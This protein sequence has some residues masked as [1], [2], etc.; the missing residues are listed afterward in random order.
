MRRS[1]SFLSLP[2]TRLGGVAL[3]GLCGFLFGCVP[4]VYL[5][6]DTG[7]RLVIDRGVDVT[8]KES[9]AQQRGP[10]T[11]AEINQALTKDL[12]RIAIPADV[13]QAALLVPPASF[14]EAFRNLAWKCTLAERQRRQSSDVQYLTFIGLLGAG[15]VSSTAAATLG[16]LSEIPADGTAKT[17]LKASGI[18]MGGLA[19][20]FNSLMAAT[21]IRKSASA[22]R[23]KYG[24]AQLAL[25][26]AQA[27]WPLIE[28][29]C[30]DKVTAQIKDDAT[31][32]AADKSTAASA[33][34][35]EQR[36]LLGQCVADRKRKILLR[37]ST[38]CLTE[39][40]VMGGE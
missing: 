20:I 25:G 21:A 28:D 2:G 5:P 24:E 8:P 26:D 10:V 29:S 30:H 1:R 18:V 23:A 11:A 14:E 7:K 3:G 6:P 9:G 13:T 19:V 16:G 34:E 27:E 35:A 36:R 39:P 15:L 31:S 17:A 4:Y 37:L 38:R 32:A 22:T 33:G 40:E 12:V